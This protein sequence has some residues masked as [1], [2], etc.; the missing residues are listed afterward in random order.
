M[1]RS[2]KMWAS[3]L[4]TFYSLFPRGSAFLFPLLLFFAL[5]KAQAGG[6]TDCLPNWDHTKEI[7]IDNTSNAS[8][9]YGHQ[10]N[11]YLNTQNL[12]TAGELQSDGADLRFMT[13]DCDLLCHSVDGGMNTDSTDIWVKVDTIAGGSM[14]T[15][16]MYYGNAGASDVT[17]SSCVFDFYEGFED[18]NTNNWS[19]NCF[20]NSAATCTGD[21]NTGSCGGDNCS[22]TTATTARSNKGSYSAE[23]FAEASCF[24]SPYNG[25]VNEF[26][27]TITVPNGDYILEFHHKEHNNMH[28][29]CSCSNCTANNINLCIDGTNDYSS[30]PNCTFDNCNECEDPWTQGQSSCFNVSGGSTEVTFWEDV[31]DCQEYTTWLDDIRLRKCPSPPASVG[32]TIDPLTMSVSTNDPTCNNS[33]GSISIGVNGGTSPYQYSNDGGSTWQGSNSF[34]GLAAGT[35]QLVVE[36]SGGCTIDTSV[37]LT[38]DPVPSDLSFNITAATCG[39]SNGE[40]EITGVTGGTTPYQY[41]FDG[42]GFSN[43]TV[44]TGLAS[45]TYTVTVQDSNG[46]TYSENVNVPNAGGLAIDTVQ[47]TDNSCNGAC[48]G[49]LDIQVSGGSTPYQYSNDDG[50]S[51]QAGNVF[52]NLCAGTYDVVVEDSSGCRDSAQVTIDEPS[53]VQVSVSPD[54]TICIGGTATLSASASGGTPGYTY[55]W[56]NGLGTGQSHSV[57]PGSNTTYKVVA[58]DANGCF[59][60]SVPVQV[61]YHPPLQVSTSQDDSICPG[62]SAQLNA[63]GSGGIGSGYS[64]SWSNGMSGNSI[65]VAPGSTQDY[66]VTLEDGCETPPVTD[67]VTVTVN[68]LPNVAFDGQNLTG[69][70]PV[71]ATLINST[72]DSMVGS[73]CVWSFGDG[74]E[75]LGCDTVQHLYDEPGCYDVTLRVQS[76]EGCVDSTTATDFVC[77]YPYPTADFS[78]EPEETTV[79]DPAINF[80]NLSTGANSY[81]WDF[82]GLDSSKAQHPSFEFPDDEA[83]TY[84]VC[85]AAENGY[86]CVDTTCRSV[87]IDGEFLLYV[88]NA[89]T[90]DGD[91]KNDRF[92]PVVQGADPS[93]YHFAIYD[94]WGEVVFETQDPTEKWDGSIKG[95]KNSSKTDVYVWKL[96]V[97]SKYSKKTFQRQGHVTLIR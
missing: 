63:N 10:I 15:I 14:D 44:Y 24:C 75:A 57:S 74:Q 3:M 16:Y 55:H 62:N 46:C 38:G 83:G 89:F 45:G 49:S 4:I 66:V 52:N 72:A 36:E 25:P 71:N 60:D 41:D 97:K 86:G 42:S 37:T 91:G 40:V 87:S 43:S 58:E 50:S 35:Y 53:A 73:D 59:S 77:V 39:S 13:D 12:I 81:S 92:G 2:S 19:S 26:Q 78:F 65:S 1:H 47:I 11:V 64:Y 30:P 76:P 31:G 96:V 88:P 17:D 29:Y 82:A 95:D 18:G 48:D 34:S 27:R 67:T 70:R 61:N 21:P 51:F 85:L 84:E 80:T 22:A 23:M 68:E 20:Q 90:P 8:D 9:L 5:P 56:N 69:C 28:G 33:D 7:V 54:T 94:R 6:C 32:S 93:S 79:Q